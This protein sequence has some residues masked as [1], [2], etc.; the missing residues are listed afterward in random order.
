M[1]LVG[2]ALNWDL[3]RVHQCIFPEKQKPKD[4]TGFG[5]VIIH[6]MQ[7]VPARSDDAARMTAIALAAKRYWGYPE[8]WIESWRD[9]LTVSPEFIA[10]HEIHVLVREG[11]IVGFYALGRQPEKMELLHMWVLPEVMGRGVGKA[12]F[13]HAI[14]RVRASGCS[15][16]EIEF[17]PN[18]EGF[19]VR[20]GGRRVGLRVSEIEQQRRELPILSFQIDTKG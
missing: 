9:L 8:S 10:T 15:E 6:S 20:M 17:D 7:I 5:R 4:V 3:L 18:A 1:T 2:R 19:Y 12:L 11:E 13:L 16:L 14:E